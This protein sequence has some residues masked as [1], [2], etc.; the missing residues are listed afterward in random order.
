MSEAKYKAAVTKLVKTVTFNTQ[1]EVEKALR[2]A[3]AT[4][5]IQGDE[6][7]TIS[8]ALSN[9]KIGLDLTIFS[10]IKL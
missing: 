9:D 7:L 6:T 1:R 5:R 4:G 8:V 10:K 3:I 2:Q